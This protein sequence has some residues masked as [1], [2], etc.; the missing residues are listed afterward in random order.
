[1]LIPRLIVVAEVVALIQVTQF[2]FG[3]TSV[4]EKDGGLSDR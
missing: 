3:D 1:M 4:V 2:T